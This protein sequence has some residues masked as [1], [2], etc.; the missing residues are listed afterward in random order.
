MVS[1]AVDSSLLRVCGGYSE[2]V[3]GE[4]KRLNTSPRMRR[5]LT[6]MSM[7]V[8]HTKG[9]IGIGFIALMLAD[10][11]V[12]AAEKGLT[13]YTTKDARVTVTAGKKK[14]TAKANKKGVVR[15]I[16]GTSD[17]NVKISKKGY[18]TWNQKYS[19]TG[20]GERYSGTVFNDEGV[21]ERVIHRKLLK[22][23]RKKHTLYGSVT[24]TSG[25]SE[26]K[27]NFNGTIKAKSGSHTYKTKIVNGKYAFHNIA[28]GYYKVSGTSSFML[29][30]KK[31]TIRYS[32]DVVAVGKKTK[33]GL[34]AYCR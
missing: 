19:A 18:Y 27:K 17:V 14:G 22:K 30:N 32:S 2:V 7:E 26:M 34:F 9:K 24:S 16:T 8:I 1:F 23:T 28:A 6:I 29:G 15:F 31:K 12:H 11:P 25:P 13:I 4:T 3:N 33:A 10:T 5:L 20:A 21:T